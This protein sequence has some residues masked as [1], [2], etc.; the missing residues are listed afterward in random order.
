VGGYL[1]KRRIGGRANHTGIFLTLVPQL[2][3]HTV[4]EVIEPPIS[5]G[6]R[7]HVFEK[8][9]GALSAKLAG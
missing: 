9:C 3:V 7:G 5:G 6:F 4:V 2:L 1:L 8:L